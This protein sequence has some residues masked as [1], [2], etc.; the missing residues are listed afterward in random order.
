MRR[1]IIFDIE[2]RREFEE[3]VAWY[4]ARQPGL[5]DRFE[6]EVDATFR[7]ILQNPERF[8]LIGDTVRKAK[9]RIFPYNVYYQIQAG[10][11]GVVSVF[12]GRR[13]P[14]ELLRRIK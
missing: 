10:F 12:H 8:R 1:E 5:G 13:H 4:D 7:R 11:I 6:A 2:A 14:A 3:A 9:V